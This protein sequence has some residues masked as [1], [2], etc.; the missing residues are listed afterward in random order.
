M[1]H[2]WIL[3]QHSLPFLASLSQRLAQ[4][5][6]RLSRALDR[7]PMLIQQLV[8]AYHRRDQRSL[9]DLSHKLVAAAGSQPSLAA[10]ADELQQQI[11]SRQRRPVQR[12]LLALIGEAGSLR[13][14]GIFP[15]VPKI[16]RVASIEH[17]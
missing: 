3:P 16:V 4:D 9:R 10:V 8:S 2:A 1:A 14:R 5:N 11:E 7:L 6:R 12:S 13:S 17:D 15:A